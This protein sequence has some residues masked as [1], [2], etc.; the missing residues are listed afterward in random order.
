LALRRQGGR[1]GLPAR[2][3]AAARAAPALPG[4]EQ[5]YRA[6]FE[7]VAV[8]ITRVDL[9]GVLVDLNQK[10]G[11]ML[12]YS[13][14]ELLGKT[15]RD[16]THP[17]DYG[18]GTR[19]RAEVTHGDAQ[20]RTGEKRFL[21][22]DGSV[23]WARRT[24]SSVCDEAG[25]P[26]YV[27]SVV[28]DITERKAV[29]ER[30]R[31]TF[32]NAPIGIMHT[33]I[34]DDRILHANAKLTE[35]LGYS[36]DELMRMKTD[37]FIH[38]DY[39][40]IDQPK[41]RER[42]LKGEINAFSSERL[43]RRKDGSDLWVNRTVSLTRDS[44]GEPL[45]FIR[46]IED[47][48]ERKRAEEA[49]ARER[50]LLRTIIDT[51]P[52]F[53]YVKDA[54]GRFR[55][56]NKAWLRE[57]NIVNGDI[58]GKTVFDV[59]TSPLA[60]KMQMQDEAVVRTGVPV[61]DMEQRIVLKAPEG[62]QGKTQWTSITKVPMRD[63]S[64][65]IVGTVG[66]SRD[67]TERKRAEEALRASEE[68]LRATFDQ[69]SVGISFS[70]PDLRFL[71]MNDRYCD[72]VGYSR[73]ELMEMAVLDVQLPD[74]VEKLRSTCGKLVSGQIASSVH[75]KQL[76]RKDGSTVWCEITMSL[77]RNLDGTPRHFVT[78]TQD[79]SEQ[80]TAE[81]RQVMEHSVTRVLAEASTAEEA[82]PQLIRTICESL[83][84]AC[85]AHWQW[86]PD[87]ELLRVTGSWHIGVPGVAEFV[88]ASAGTLNEAP[89]WT[90]EAPKTKTGGLVRRVWLGGAPAWIPD[91][92]REPGFRRGE[93][94]IRAGL[95]CAFGFPILAGARPLGVLEFFG[96]DIK[97]PDETLLQAVQAIGRQIG[98]FI[99]R[100]E[101][102]QALRSSEER[103]RDLF[104]ASPLPIWVW[105]GETLDILAVNQAAIQH[106]GFT[107]D[108]FL[109]M[110]V[111]DLWE[112]SDA[113]RYEEHIRDRA[114]LHNLQLQR[115][116]R[117]RDG[118][119]IDVEVTARRFVLSG[120]TVWLTLVNDITDRKRAEA[121]LRESEEQFKQLAGNIPQ[122]FWITDVRHRDTIYISP[123]AAGMLGRPL[124]ELYRNA[125]CLVQAVHPE[126]RRRVHDARKF[127]MRGGYDETYRVVR[128]DGTIRWVNDRA[129][130]V[131]DESGNVYR[132]AG[133]AE[134]VTE[135]KFAEEQ[136]MQLAHYDVLTR[137]PNRALFYDRMKQALAQ[138]KRNQWTV[139]VMFID[140]DRFKNVND[141]L[142][143]AVGDQ[144]LQQ[145]SER[146]SRSV[147]AGDTVGRLG[148]DEF[149]IV[150]SNFSSVLDANLVAQKIMAGF[151]EPF[152]LE[153]SDIYATASIGITLFPDDSSDQDTLIRNADAA[154]YRA[155]EAGRNAY[156]FYTSG[157]NARAVETLSLESSLRRA[158][159]RNE[160]LLHFQ[161]KASVTD[162]HIIG[163]EALLR[164]QHP[165][166]GV[167]SP[168]EFM[169]VL[170]ETGL[171][172]PA[173]NWVL[174]S[175]CAQIKAWERQGI[176]LLPVAV[177]LSARQF[178]ARDFGP[179]IRRLL[180]EHRI[181]PALLDLEI[182]ESSL[183]TNTEDAAR[184][185]EYLSSLGVGLA[186]DDFGT[187]YSSL[188]YLKRFPLDAL[189]ID[190]SF[191]RDLT[192]DV[193]DATITRAVISMAHNL[194]LKVIAEGVETEAQL[195]FLA[196]HGCDQIQGYFF[197]RPL[198]ADECG[199]W[200]RQKRRLQRIQRTAAA[201]AAV[202]S[203]A[204]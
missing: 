6:M 144:L 36:L 181:D 64:G 119:A 84:W 96:R 68:I 118:R 108:E 65:D 172:M 45:Y 14:A 169:R 115:R 51:V 157:M 201:P 10:F 123:A 82:I 165:E 15:I 168:G 154:M 140:L 43:Y 98:L 27:I 137:L 197:S 12:G 128:P 174:R 114:E 100:K 13:R 121:A 85:G 38:P 55:L 78:I 202:F 196:E 58:T 34:E 187:G 143:H 126:D 69:A 130:P 83:G 46:I 183:M 29:E 72:I 47:I 156:Q 175:V 41:Y 101:A 26:Q 40:G 120:R 199:E 158:L 189:K 24:M 92:T 31:A 173:G 134:D 28:E 74:E 153:G 25:N 185:L 110:N 136:L 35:M 1:R 129:F 200:L 179:M 87:R 193:D 103:Y 106:Y 149:A 107:R 99:Q 77:V 88:A 151:D 21:R 198:P 178:I 59:F 133:I 148:G 71:Q 155:K 52:D 192:T 2:A 180:E 81:L 159:E 79:I 37:D 147:R 5:Q 48:S 124:Q 70:T 177:N 203:N 190:R 86:D 66:I 182:T 60:E 94:A 16:I 162:G 76:V 188:S 102:E 138:A 73:E 18:Q 184:T 122:A 19:Y 91:V 142:G 204:K 105:D 3:V 44:A 42:L 4:T 164:W 61:L 32:E 127:A 17:D 22:K 53:I 141:T 75:E 116:H 97:Q 194:S 20:S 50:V 23:M 90:G 163:T 195:A 89:A 109:R 63:T 117:T 95:H 191:V 167:V 9:D 104:E 113:A 145:V 135:K 166:R 161:P 30:H 152:R 7:N 170:E 186:I 171:I 56:A 93:N 150:L 80:K 111:R 11:D 176:G 57:R 67:I 39:V 132:I 112:S 160:F 33:A 139:G 62:K 54:D 125:R 8:G 49:V 146:L 131:Q